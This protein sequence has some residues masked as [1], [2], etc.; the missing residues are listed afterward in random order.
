[1]RQAGTT[2]PCLRRTKCEVRLN[3]N[4]RQGP[5]DFDNTAPAVKVYNF[6][7]RRSTAPGTQSWPDKFG[8]KS[9]A[10]AWRNGLVVV[11]EVEG[12][13]HPVGVTKSRWG[14]SGVLQVEVQGNWLVPERVWTRDSVKGL[15]STG[16]LVVDKGD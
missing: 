10:D 6:D 9:V 5:G 2:A 13:P 8:P 1:M 16:E 7:H 14:A 12:I 15:S 11:A 4:D 3:W